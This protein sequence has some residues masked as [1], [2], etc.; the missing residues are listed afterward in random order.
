[1][2]YVNAYVENSSDTRRLGV[3]NVIRINEKF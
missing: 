1:M 2:E 3:E